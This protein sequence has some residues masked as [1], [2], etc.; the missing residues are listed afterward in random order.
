MENRKIGIVQNFDEVT[1]EV[2]I[3]N[4]KYY[5][6]YTSLEEKVKNGD[7]VYFEV[8]NE[9][10]GTVNNIRKYK[11]YENPDDLFEEEQYKLER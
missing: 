11:N 10:I 4:K 8:I 7:E 3:G 9:T 2:V 5:F 1:G 6:P